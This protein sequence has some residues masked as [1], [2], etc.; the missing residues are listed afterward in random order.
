MMGA[1]FLSGEEQH[2]R[3]TFAG[4]RLV[5]TAGDEGFFA[6]QSTPVVKTHSNTFEI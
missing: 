3:S 6:R 2:S 4:V 1:C 5:S